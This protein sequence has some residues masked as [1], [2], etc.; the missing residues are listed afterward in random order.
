MFHA[1]FHEQKGWRVMFD[2]LDICG[3]ANE[4]VAR[5]TARLM[6]LSRADHYRRNT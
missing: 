3:A 5:E 4:A 2:Q 6:Q 1:F